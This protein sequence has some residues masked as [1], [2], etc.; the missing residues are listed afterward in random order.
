MIGKTL[1]RTLVSTVEQSL[2]DHGVRWLENNEA[3]EKNSEKRIFFSLEQKV[4]TSNVSICMW[5]K[6]KIFPLLP[7]ATVPLEL[8]NWK[9][10]KPPCVLNG[11][12]E[13]FVMLPRVG[14]DRAAW[15]SF[16]S[17]RGALNEFIIREARQKPEKC[18]Y[19]HV[20]KL[21][22]AKGLYCIR[23]VYCK[24]CWGSFSKITWLIFFL[25]HNKQNIIPW[26][27][28]AGCSLQ[29]EAG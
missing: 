14:E 5:S 7:L 24:P 22:Y 1:T 16:L 15:G 13:K 26:Y 25:Q 28:L 27:L 9:E 19:V 10:E 3:S 4:G 17:S 12:I 21:C 8:G 20:C 11:Q 2:V 29:E 23:E 6:Y 18:V